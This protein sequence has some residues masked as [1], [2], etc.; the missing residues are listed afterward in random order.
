MGSNNSRI[1]GEKAIKDIS[2][3]TER[4]Y[5]FEALTKCMMEAHEDANVSPKSLQELQTI[6]SEENY[7]KETTRWAI[8]R[9]YGKYFNHKK[10]RSDFGNAMRQNRYRINNSKKIEENKAIIKLCAEIKLTTKGINIIKSNMKKSYEKNADNFIR[11]RKSKS[12]SK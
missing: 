11:K 12:K 5:D 9:I 2:L 10:F 8:A 6:Y 3:T 4:S 1:K 7:K